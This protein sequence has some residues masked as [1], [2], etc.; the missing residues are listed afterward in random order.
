MDEE[1]MK[2]QLLLLGGTE[3][4]MKYPTLWSMAIGDWRVTRHPYIN[5]LSRDKTCIDYFD[6]GNSVKQKK[7]SYLLPEQVIDLIIG[8]I[9]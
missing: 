3:K 1:T 7:A 2:A 4:N 8:E 9:K 5:T 6:V